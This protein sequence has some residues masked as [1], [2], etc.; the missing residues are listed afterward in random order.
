VT[1]PV[2]PNGNCVECHMPS[3]PRDSFR[4]VDHWIR[5]AGPST[6][7]TAGSPWRAFLRMILVPTRE[8]AERIHDE[9]TRGAKFADLARRYS[10]DPS[11]ENGGFLGA[12]QFDQMKPPLA[13]AVAQLGYGEYSAAIDGGRAFYLFER[14]PRDFRWRADQLFLQ[15]KVR[16]ALEINPAFLR[17]LLALGIEAGKRGDAAGAIAMLETA[18]RLYPKDTGTQLNLGIAYGAAGRIEAEI[19][20]YQRA[21]EGEPDLVAARLNLGAAYLAA[22][23]VA[24]AEKAYRDAIEANPLSAAAYNNLSIVLNERHRPAEA[25]R[26]A[27]Q[28]NAIGHP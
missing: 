24:A 1:C 23:Q 5:V 8:Q 27:A 18:A 3:Q 12:M 14:Q 4:M 25:R 13:R 7:K 20:A 15:G 10:K 16:E 2:N 28:A 6:R 11:A 17:A 22:G 9:L 19:A 26:A 21:L